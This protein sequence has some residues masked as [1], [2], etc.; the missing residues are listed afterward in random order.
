[1]SN[2]DWGEV[3]SWDGNNAN[4]HTPTHIEPVESM[5]DIVHQLE[6]CVDVEETAE[7]TQEPVEETVSDEPMF[8]PLYCNNCIRCTHLVGPLGKKA[9]DCMEGN[10]N[11]PAHDVQLGVG[12]SPTLVPEYVRA[13]SEGDLPC[14]GSINSKLEDAHPIAVR[15]F[16]KDV[17]AETAALAP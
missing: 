6:E 14:L 1:M 5:N 2:S 7:T 17:R 9:G 8:L 3:P 15:E 16:L 13:L 4:T 10:P 12:V 11:C